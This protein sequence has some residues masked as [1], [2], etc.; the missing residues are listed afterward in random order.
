M[1]YLM[2]APSGCGHHL[3]MAANDLWV[4]RDGLIGEIDNASFHYKPINENRIGDNFLYTGSFPHT[5]PMNA[6]YRPDLIEIS[7]IKKEKKLIYVY[8]DPWE[9]AMSCYNRWKT[10]DKNI[11]NHAQVTLDNMMYIA[12][13]IEEY[14][15]D[16]V[17][18]NYRDICRNPEK[19]TKATG[20]YLDKKEIKEAKPY[21]GSKELVRFFKEREP[22]YS[23]LI[24]NMIKL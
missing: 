16:A 5:Y 6:T 19:F 21:S 17:V 4:K 2:I 3:F 23:K 9:A 8:R 13:Y 11:F 10:Q 12:K 14:D 7:K 24:K 20:L 18:Y 22:L 1:I 15:N